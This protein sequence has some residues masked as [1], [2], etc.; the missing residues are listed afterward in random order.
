LIFDGYENSIWIVLVVFLCFVLV[1]K[2]ILCYD[3]RKRKQ[4]ILP[5]VSFDCLWKQ[6]I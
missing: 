1:K 6:V 5:R 4:W 3:R 2:R